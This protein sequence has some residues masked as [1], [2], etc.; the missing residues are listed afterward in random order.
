MSD[1]AV[2]REQL[3]AALEEGNVTVWTKGENV[4]GYM[5]EPT[6]VDLSGYVCEVCGKGMDAHTAELARAG[7]GRVSNFPGVPYSGWRCP[8]EDAP[9]S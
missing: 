3:L 6:E 4:T 7:V 9:A 1:E 5:D 8:P 2:T